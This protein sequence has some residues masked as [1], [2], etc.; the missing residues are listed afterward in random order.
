MRIEQ[1]YGSEIICIRL[2]YLNVLLGEFRDVR[3]AEVNV[4]ARR[5][6]NLTIVRPTVFPQPDSPTGRTS[7][8]GK[9]Q[10]TSSTAFKIRR[11]PKEFPTGK[12]IL[13]VFDLN[14]RFVLHGSHLPFNLRRVRV[15]VR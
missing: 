11:L 3:A 7:R 13:R 1:A 6:V 10:L 9:A 4:P 8:R 12:C 15:H 14:E 5:L 2:R